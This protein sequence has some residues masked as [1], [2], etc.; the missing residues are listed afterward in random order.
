MPNIPAQLSTF[1]NAVTDE[2]LGVNSVTIINTEDL[3]SL[4]E[5][6]LSSAESTSAFYSAFVNVI[7]RA[8][9]MYRQLPENRLGLMRTPLEFGAIL[10]TMTVRNMARTKDN[11]SW[12]ASA[13]ITETILNDTT[14]AMCIYDS[15][16][17]TFEIETKVIYDYQLRTAFHDAESMAAFIELIFTDMYNG[18]ELAIRDMENATVC[19][20]IA[21]AASA[22]LTSNCCINLL[23]KYNAQFGQSLTASAAITDADFLKFAA[24]EIRKT[25]K[26]M[27]DPSRLY[28]PLNYE[29]FTPSSDAQLHVLAEFA[30]NT[31][32][33]LQSDTFHDDLVKLPTY[34][35]RSFWQG[36]G[37]GSFTQRAFVSVQ[38]GSGADTV[39]TSVNN[40]L[41]FCFDY[42][43][44]A[45]MIDFI[46]TKSDYKA[47]Y[48]H[49]E[50][51][52]KADWASLV[53]PFEQMVVFYIDD[54]IPIA[55]VPAADVSDWSN[56]YT[57]YSVK[58]Q[59]T[60]AYST[61]S[62][63]YDADIPYYISA[64]S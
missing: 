40:V 52:H 26:Y 64:A 42:N 14:D 9:A 54:Y 32:T 58:N 60:G 3:V 28:N 49:T 45:V 11:T 12:D 31:A 50:Y 39:D 17:G 29:R 47:R 62:S 15:R 44:I 16:R 21:A 24:A 38:R 46:R 13:S 30:S 5:T 48:E 34:R 37:D 7:G 63:T 53:R 59:A 55:E 57:K 41:A 6:V 23:A 36:S 61:A 51:Y 33:Y 43:A 56:Q 19:T 1:L 35:E 22:E 25:K 27:E 20:A 2:M 18:M 8:Y 4:G 10:R